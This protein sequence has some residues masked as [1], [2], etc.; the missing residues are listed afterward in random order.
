MMKVIYPVIFTEVDTNILIEVPDL[1]IT[2]S[3]YGEIGCF[4]VNG[5]KKY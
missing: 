2:G 1:R 3:T 5:S 4:Q